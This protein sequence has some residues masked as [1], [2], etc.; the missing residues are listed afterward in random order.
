VRFILPFL[1]FL[2]FVSLASAITVEEV[3]KL[4][5]L[6]TSDDVI[7]KAIEKS[8]LDKPLSSK[9]IVYLKEQGVSD[10]VISA[11]MEKKEEKEKEGFLRVY[12][13]TDKKGKR[14]TVVTN[15]DE[16]GHRM[17]GDIPP[18]VYVPERSESNNAYELPKEIHVTIQQEAQP[19]RGSRDDYYQEEQPAPNGIPLYDM[20]YPAYYPGYPLYSGYGGSFFPRSHRCCRTPFPGS[21]QRNSGQVDWNFNAGYTPA[22]RIFPL[23][24]QTPVPGSSA[25]FRPSR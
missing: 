15:L 1:V 7:L 2:L 9:D 16:S 14:V 8:K 17:G 23:R 11:L 13:T 12:H 22:P 6:H 20:N 10:R 4:T 24:P 5:K 3:V 25:G 21:F 19:E 18:E